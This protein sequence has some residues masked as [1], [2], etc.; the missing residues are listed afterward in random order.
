MKQFSKD[1][2]NVSLAPKGKWSREQEYEKLALV[3][4]ACDNLSY[5]AKINVPSGVD[6]ENREYWQPMNATGYADNNFINLTTENENGIITAYENIE[7]AVATILP[8]NRRAGATLSFYNLNSDRLDRQAEFELWQFNS[9]DL[10][11]WENKDY[12]NN[13]YYNWNV[14]VG[15][16][17]GA[18]ALKNH[19]KL[20]TVGQ[21]AYVGTNLN[22][23]L[24]YQCRT[25]GVWTNTG[26]KVRNYISVVVSGNIT[27]GE[28]GNWFSD[29]EDTGIPATPAVDEQ[30]DNIIMQLQQHATEI[31]KLQKQDVVLK[32][33]I[34]SN[35]EIIN[36][37][38]DNIKT[39]TDNKIDT[40]DANL[41][42]QITSN[43]TDI[44]TINTK[45]ESLSRT[46]QGIA[47]TGGASTATN[48]TYNNDANGLNAENAQDAIDELASKKFDKESVAQEPGYAKNKVMSQN[49]LVNFLS[50]IDP[51]LP[52]RY[53]DDSE[54]AIEDYDTNS[55]KVTVP[56]PK[57]SSNYNS[58]F[59]NI[60][61]DF[62]AE[63]NKLIIN[64]RYTYLIYIKARQDN[65][66][67]TTINNVINEK[68]KV[69]P[70]AVIKN[71][72]LL[73][74]YLKQFSFLNVA[75]ELGNDT[76]K[77]VSQDLLSKYIN[78][79]GI[80]EALTGLKM[81]ALLDYDNGTDGYVSRYPDG[82]IQSE[83]GKYYIHKV[84]IGKRY[85]LY[86]PPINDDNAKNVSIAFYPSENSLSGK[87]YTALKNGVSIY[88]VVAEDNYIAFSTFGNDKKGTHFVIYELEEQQGK[89]DLSGIKPTNI[90][91]LNSLNSA[92]NN[93]FFSTYGIM[94]YKI[95]IPYKSI[96]TKLSFY[97]NKNGKV[98]FGLGSIDQRNW[99]IINSTF[100][101]DVVQ[102]FNEI[103]VFSLG[104]KINRYG[105]LYL[106]AY[107]NYYNNC[108]IA[109]VPSS[110]NNLVYSDTISGVLTE[111]KNTENPNG[112][113]INIKVE[114]SL[115]NLIYSADSKV[116]EINNWVV[117]N[118]NL[119]AFNNFHRGE[120][121]I[122][123][124]SYK[125]NKTGNL[126]EV[127]Y[128]NIVIFGNSIFTHGSISS[129]LEPVVINGNTWTYTGEP[130]PENML[131]MSGRGMGATQQEF[132]FKHLLRKKLKEYN[133]DIKIKGTNI[134]GIERDL[135]QSL[136]QYLLD[137]ITQETDVFIWRAGENVSNYKDDY[138]KAL[139]RYIK[140]IK[141][142]NN[143]IK[144]ILT[145]RFW[146]NNVSDEFVFEASRDTKSSFIYMVYED[147]EELANG[148]FL[149]KYPVTYNGEIKDVI[150]PIRGGGGH[151]S[152]LGYYLIANRILELLGVEKLEMLHKIRVVNNSQLSYSSNT[153][154]LEGALCTIVLSGRATVSVKSDDADNTNID[155]YN[156]ADSSINNG[157]DWYF[158]MP[159]TDVIITI[160]PI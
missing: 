75:Q 33:N 37:K 67:V 27:I 50:Y 115:D 18:D 143:N 148:S 122:D 156:L 123:G 114:Y 133:A 45:H 108:S 49:S 93:K 155:V 103:D 40:A 63:T 81:V 144:I 22:D 130:D 127:K 17:I 68:S 158:Y 121:D 141:S 16:Y 53:I 112:A 126:S 60:K 135:P 34:D 42:N 28:N 57:K 32:S 120:I 104:L 106:F 86:I 118:I 160:N 83:V 20:P 94:C 116:D 84:E 5:V 79:S 23:A 124:K 15:W 1:L 97:A 98:L 3:Y 89:I 109:Y 147:S 95:Y 76:K 91:A 30:L 55:V 19:V 100:T 134:A 66:F 82:H 13:I 64:K 9:T 152:N 129:Y 31:D 58:L 43:D 136:P 131:G 101:L 41:Q 21:Y 70:I 159:N 132:D 25:N 110:S 105:G 72:S 153:K 74:N 14:F 138:F 78:L 39:D 69:I 151:P 73:I 150:R 52:Y 44:A 107:N 7:E 85:R 8:I 149:H 99:A 62:T 51:V 2:G 157:N 26:I 54:I 6:I 96:L 128:N 71:G 140:Q 154:Q 88:D 46:V 119:N 38:V 36:N 65:F 59:Y 11:N 142:K 117:K 35:F 90:K 56:L 87:K 92:E 139:K 137:Y 102:G 80:K 61:E 4:N 29:G 111:L 125:L 77:I 113:A 48:V 47:A 10:A 145:S 146:T 24:L 12:W